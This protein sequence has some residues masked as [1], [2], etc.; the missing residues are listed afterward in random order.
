MLYLLDEELIGAMII[1]TA[2]GSVQ[3]SDVD[4]FNFLWYRM[5]HVERYSTLPITNM[6]W[7]EY[8]MP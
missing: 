4:N 6:S 8:D 2:I 3:R 7:Y 5:S 1:K